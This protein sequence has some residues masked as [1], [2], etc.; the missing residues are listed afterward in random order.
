MRNK[1]PVSKL[2]SY[3]CVRVIHA[4]HSTP[5]PH[6]SSRNRGS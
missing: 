4:S 2:C 3:W 5:Y 6:L 1:M